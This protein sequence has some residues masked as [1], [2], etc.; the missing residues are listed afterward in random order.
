MS[1][2]EDQEGRKAFYFDGFPSFDVRDGGDARISSTVEENTRLKKDLDKTS[3]IQRPMIPRQM[4]Y[5]YEGGVPEPHQTRS[6]KTQ[7]NVNIT[8]RMRAQEQSNYK[9]LH[10]QGCM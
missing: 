8:A 9:S 4:F 10:A 2:D 1:D 5:S 3:V 7:R 6:Q